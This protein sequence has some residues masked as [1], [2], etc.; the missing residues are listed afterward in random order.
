MNPAD[1]I[2]GA[3]SIIR[4]MFSENKEYVVREALRTTR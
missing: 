3:K 1:I 4:G 2:F